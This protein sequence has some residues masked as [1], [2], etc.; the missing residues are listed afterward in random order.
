VDGIRVATSWEAPL[1][2]TL[3][4]LTAQ[5][6]SNGRS[7][8]VNWETLTEVNNFGFWVEKSPN[9]QRHYVEIP[10]S[11]TPGHGTSTEPH[12]YSFMDNSISSGA[13]YY[14][15]RQQDLDNTVHYSDGV[16]LD[17]LTDVKEQA[18]R[19]FALFQNYPNPFNPTTEIK[20]TIEENGMAV[21]KLFNILGQEVATLFAGDAEAGHYYRIS[22]DGSNFGSGVYFYSLESGQKKDN[23][24][25]LLLR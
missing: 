1:P 11:F 9:D 17:V 6:A 14:R 10:G 15:L 5:L 3:A 13:W 7:V 23:K 18:P 12:H 4:Y 8:Q 19:E 16:R 25:M 21:L 24:K 20:F 2:I 22:V